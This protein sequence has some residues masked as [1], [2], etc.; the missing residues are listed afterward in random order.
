MLLALAACSAAAPPAPVDAPPAA[1]TRVVLQLTGQVGSGYTL[2]VEHESGF[3]C[4]RVGAAP[5]VELELPA[6]PC[7]LTL[8]VGDKR[9][10]RPL[11]VGSSAPMTVVWDLDGSH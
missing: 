4:T 11:V 8:V 6:G 7:S 10:E 1:A 2:R 9:F 5:E 3:T